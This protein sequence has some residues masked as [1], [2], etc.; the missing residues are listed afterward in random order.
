MKVIS[1]LQNKFAAVLFGAAST[2]FVPLLIAAS[3]PAF[4]ASVVGLPDFTELV[5]R[6]GPAVVN[7]RTT[8]KVKNGQGI[9]GVEDEE[10]QEF[11]RRFFGVPIPPRHQPDRPPRG[12]EP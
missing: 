4:A 9:P 6:S 3:P 8:E 2:F 7:I 5:E 10:M 12:H 1:S 11:F